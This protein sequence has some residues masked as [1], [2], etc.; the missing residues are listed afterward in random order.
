MGLIQ[1]RIKTLKNAQGSKAF[2]RVGK[3]LARKLEKI[4]VQD[5]GTKLDREGEWD[6]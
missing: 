3:N 4:F 6:K 5:E 1:D 2:R